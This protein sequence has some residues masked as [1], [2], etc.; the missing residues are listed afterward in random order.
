MRILLVTAWHLGNTKMRRRLGVLGD[1]F[2]QRQVRVSTAMPPEAEVHGIGATLKTGFRPTLQPK[3]PTATHRRVL[4]APACVAQ[5]AKTLARDHK[6]CH[7]LF[8]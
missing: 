3:Y 5:E 1:R 7:S 2:S 6:T 4:A 8:F